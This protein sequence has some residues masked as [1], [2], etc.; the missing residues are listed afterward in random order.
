M[1][2]ILVTDYFY[3]VSKGGTERY[4]LLLARYLKKYFDIRVLSIH[5]SLKTNVFENL[6]IDYILPNAKDTK[7]IITGQEAPTNVG[8][9]TDYLN[10]HQPDI[11]H[12][13]TLTTN[14]N[15][16]HF[17]IAKSKK[18]KVIFTSHIPGHICLRGDFLKNGTKSCDGLVSS[19]KCNKCVSFSNNN[20]F[21][22]GISRY[23][24]Y[25]ITKNSPAILKLRQLRDIERYTDKI[26]CVAEWQ[27]EFFI[28]NG[29]NKKHITVCRQ[30]ADELHLTKSSSNKI[31]LGFI[32]RIDPVK[33]LHLL[34]E[35]MESI[36]DNHLSLQIA[37]ITPNDSRSKYFS[38]LKKISRNV[39][40]CK[41]NFDL[42]REAMIRFLNNL[43]YLVVPSL[44]FETGPFVIYEALAAKIPIITTKMGGQQELVIDGVN[45]YLHAPT[46]AALAGLLSSLHE[47]LLTVEA[48]PQRNEDMIGIEMQQ[49][50]TE[51]FEKNFN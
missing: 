6:I 12:F 39:T 18:C 29:I 31:R 1:K 15:V 13:H 30:A 10:I 2:I 41:W 46:K 27:K 4:V 40:E 7:T 25:S 3:P 16:F 37:A 32:G 8:E 47:K 14:F 49:V 11:I 51:N 35:A 34:L 24:Y 50:Y 42:D 38:T 5:H 43:D 36:N 26:V 17:K 33:G 9:F 28:K 23:L 22:K 48:V 21:L 19:Y 20:S 44:C 45:G